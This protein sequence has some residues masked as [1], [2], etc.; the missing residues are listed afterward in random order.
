V[1]VNQI[2]MVRMATPTTTPIFPARGETRSALRADMPLDNSCESRVELRARLQHGLDRLAAIVREALADVSPARPADIGDER[3]ELE[4]QRADFQAEV[5][6]WHE[7]R[8]AQ[9]EQLEGERRKLADA[10]DRLERERV[11]ISAALRHETQPAPLPHVAAP[12][13]PAAHASPA[14][15]PVA[16]EVLRQFES[17]RHDVRR[18]ARPGRAR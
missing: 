1:K 13:R 9:I 8:R 6:A 4:R 3:L 17:L 15:S 12:P 14:E 2:G 18:R 16:R 10:W 5:D 11:E 7:Q